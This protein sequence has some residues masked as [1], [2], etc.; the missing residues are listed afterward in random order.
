M[1]RLAMVLEKDRIYFGTGSDAVFI[2]DSF[3][4]ERRKWLEKDMNGR[5]K[6]S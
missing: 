5:R 1:A 2:L 3:T 4:G 6:N